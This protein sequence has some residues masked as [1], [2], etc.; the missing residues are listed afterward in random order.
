M[1]RGTRHAGTQMLVV[2]V[3]VAVVVVEEV[4][5]EVEVVVVVVVSEVAALGV[6]SGVGAV[7][8]ERVR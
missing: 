4:E 7:E 8:V 3:V 6:V 1:Q 5:M 2:A